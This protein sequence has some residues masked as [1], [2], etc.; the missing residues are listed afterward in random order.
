[1]VYTR[2][3]CSNL[4][5]RPIFTEARSAVN[6]VFDQEPQKRRALRQSDKC[7]SIRIHDCILINN[8]IFVFISLARVR[9]FGIS[10]YGIFVSPFPLPAV[11][12]A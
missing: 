12:N 5:D 4:L 7:F 3:G 2:V 9:V 1:V 6:K 8:P 11:L 10:E